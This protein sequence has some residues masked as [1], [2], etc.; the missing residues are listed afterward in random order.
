MPIVVVLRIA[1][2]AQADV[3]LF[4]FLVANLNLGNDR[5]SS[6]SRCLARR[7]E[8]AKLLINELADARVIEVADGGDDQIVGRIC[9]AEISTQ[10]LGVERFDRLAHTEN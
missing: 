5:R 2:R 4:Q 7:S 6:L 9:V 3:T 1:G 8:I 10:A